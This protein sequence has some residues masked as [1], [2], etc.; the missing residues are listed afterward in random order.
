LRSVKQFIQVVEKAAASGWN[1][2]NP[3]DEL[4]NIFKR[5]SV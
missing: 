5:L 1:A 2:F 4:A 3:L